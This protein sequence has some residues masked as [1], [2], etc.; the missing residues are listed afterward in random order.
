MLGGQRRVGVPDRGKIAEATPGRRIAGGKVD[1]GAVVF[2]SDLEILVDVGE[3][4]VF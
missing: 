1:I 2:D 3:D 4:F